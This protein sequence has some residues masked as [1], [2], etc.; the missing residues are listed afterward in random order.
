MRAGIDASEM[1]DVSTGAGSRMVKPS[2]CMASHASK[3]H[4]HPL[5]GAQRGESLI[6]EVGWAYLLFELGHS[7][8]Q[9]TSLG[10]VVDQRQ[11]AAVRIT[12][13]FGTAEPA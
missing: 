5:R 7:P 4:R 6:L 11:R 9:Q 10:V 13:F 12:G 8:L 2:S 3:T 1:E